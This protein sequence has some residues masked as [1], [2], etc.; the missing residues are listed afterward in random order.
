MIKAVIFDLDNTLYNYD[1]C[2]RKAMAELE[3]YVCSRYEI[4]RECF[5]AKF[6]EARSDIK[7]QLGNTGASHN[8]MLYMQLLLEK[9]NHKP[10]SGALELYDIYW[11]TMLDEMTLYPYVKSLIGE[12][13]RKGIIIGV[14][15]DLTAHIQHRKL[16]RLGLAEY[17]DVMVTSEEAGAEKPSS[18][19]FDRLKSKL[20]VS[21]EEMLMIGDSRSK[22]IE[23]AMSAGMNGLLFTDEDKNI[24][25][26]KVMR[27]I[28]DRMDKRKI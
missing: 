16:R 6:D 21:P 2:H 1:L 10:A 9:L 19:A 23:G 12:L 14:L 17:V 25:D 8:R 15:T 13:N 24:M 28:N 18:A 22:D 11:N 4:S 7:T 27:F 20:K 26:E 3:K 5:L